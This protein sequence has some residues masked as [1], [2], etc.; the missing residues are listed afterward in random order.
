M[1]G[2]S[3][4]ICQESFNNAYT[5]RDMI[6]NTLQRGREV[7]LGNSHSM[8]SYSL[9]LHVISTLGN[10]TKITSTCEISISTLLS[11]IKFTEQEFDVELD[12]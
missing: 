7:S 2:F 6:A 12:T 9:P 8:A 3:L 11:A 10:M 4:A 5:P 1:L